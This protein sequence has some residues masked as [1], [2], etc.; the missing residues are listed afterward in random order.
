MKRSVEGL[1]REQ[2]LARP[3]PGTWTTHEVVCHLADSEL[4]FA[5]RVKR[6]LAEDRPPLVFADPKAF[7]L[8]LASPHR[9]VAEEIELIA[10]VRRQIAAILYD[11]P[12]ESWRREG[13]HNVTGACTLRDVIAKAV[14][15][16][17]HHVRFIFEKRRA[18]R[19]SR[20]TAPHG[21][22]GSIAAA[23]TALC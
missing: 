17:E 1:S 11:A 22:A 14:T 18:P 15:H 3:I 5:E 7:V 12:E 6:I 23:R 19:L 2:C 21:S 4:L 16:L 9:N 13:V 8:A 10:L 20:L